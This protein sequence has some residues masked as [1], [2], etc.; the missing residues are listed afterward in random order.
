[1]SVISIKRPV[2]LNG[3]EDIASRDD[4][5]RRSVILELARIEDGSVSDDAEVMSNFRK[6]VPAI[7]GALCT[8]LMTALKNIDTVQINNITSMSRFC[9]WSGASMTAFNWNADMFMKNYHDNLN[10]S[11]IAALDTSPFTAAIIKMFKDEPDK[12]WNGTPDG[13]REHLE[14]VM[15]DNPIVVIPT[16]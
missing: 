9:R 3:I 15:Y 16:L 2:I 11:Y 5:V 13:L 4:L 10:R 7:F 1:M 14:D 12:D 6:D 8:G